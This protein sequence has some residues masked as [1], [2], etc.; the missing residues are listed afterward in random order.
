MAGAHVQAFGLK[1]LA[2]VQACL[3]TRRHGRARLRNLGGELVSMPRVVESGVGE[4]ATPCPVRHA[5]AERLFR[6]H[7]EWLRKRLSRRFGPDVADDIVQDT[8][9]RLISR[10][11]LD[12]LERPK[13]FLVRVAANLVLDRHR[14]S[15]AR[16]SC[17]SIDGLAKPLSIEAGQTQT[18][19][20]KQIIVSM[21]EPMRIVFVLSRFRGW[22]YA[23]IAAHLNISA[24][25]VEWRMS[26]ALDY[27]TER[28]RD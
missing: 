7:G 27:C 3:N 16:P 25:T 12:S 4:E 22:T 15:D 18:I 23:A 17:V 20:L 13:P 21:P 11:D 9:T 1:A 26:K 6:K 24:K 5:A 28:L 2:H 10:G 8:W 14:R 19:L